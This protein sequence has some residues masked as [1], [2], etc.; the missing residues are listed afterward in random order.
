MLHIHFTWNMTDE[1]WHVTRELCGRRYI[2]IPKWFHAWHVKRYA[3]NMKT[4]L[5]WP[6]GL[7]NISITIAF[8][9]GSAP[10]SSKLY[11][12]KSECAPSSY[13]PLHSSIRIIKY[14]PLRTQGCRYSLSGNSL[15]ISFL[16]RRGIA[17]IPYSSLINPSVSSIFVVAWAATPADVRGFCTVSENQK[18]YSLKRVAVNTKTHGA[19]WASVL[20]KYVEPETL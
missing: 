20:E 13:E 1:T 9:S 8:L 10:V 18:Q 14:E 4:W 2:E 11:N 12:E 15:H 6:G 19:S 16:K 7:R 3:W 5:L 17:S